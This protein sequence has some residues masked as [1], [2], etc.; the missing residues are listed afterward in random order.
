MWD[1]SGQPC[2]ALCPPHSLTRVR[3]WSRH[4][5]CLIPISCMEERKLSDA[6]VLSKRNNDIMNFFLKGLL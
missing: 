2:V 1:S 3:W 5:L 4:L 6:T